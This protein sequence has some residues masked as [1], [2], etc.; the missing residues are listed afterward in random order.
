MT[1][2]KQKRLLDCSVLVLAGY[3]A[4]KVTVNQLIKMGAGK[5][6]IAFDT[7]SQLKINPEDLE[8]NPDVDIVFATGSKRESVEKLV[9]ASNLV[10]ETCSNWQEK[11]A[12]SDLCMRNQ[13]PLIH[14][15]GEDLRY[16]IFCMIPGKSACLR[17]AF[18]VAGIDDF[19]HAA[20]RNQNNK[21]ELLPVHGMVGSLMALEAIKVIAGLGVS[22]GNE[23][24]K[25]DGFSGEFE[26]IRGLD[27]RYDC[28]D[29]GKVVRH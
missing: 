1:A 9:E 7:S 6:T 27:P 18:P 10:I 25:F 8:Q 2:K 19:P 12:L 15:G 11:L 14:C 16:Q 26:V 5:I 20:N 21:P 22:Q 3:P 24:W 13:I 4:A 29:C 23:M 17:C 28:P